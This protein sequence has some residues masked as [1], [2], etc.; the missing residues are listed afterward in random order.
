MGISGNRITFLDLPV[1][2]CFTGEMSGGFSMIGLFLSIWIYTKVRGTVHRLPALLGIWL[3]YPW[4]LDHPQYISCPCDAA[5][6]EG[7]LPRCSQRAQR[8]VLNVGSVVMCDSVGPAL[9][10][11][12]ANAQVRAVLQPSLGLHRPTTF[13]WPLEC[14]TSS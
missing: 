12:L 8:L 4:S 14:S 9:L 3:N 11:L 5:T 2:M 1:K 7:D 13:S 6:C 10:D